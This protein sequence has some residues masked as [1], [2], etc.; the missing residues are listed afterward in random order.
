MSSQLILPAFLVSILL[1]AVLFFGLGFIINMLI[2]T[3]WLPAILYPV[4]I[5]LYIDDISTLDY[6]TQFGSSM[7]ALGEKMASLAPSDITVLSAGWIGAI[8][9]GIVMKMLRSRGYQMF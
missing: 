2:K 9:S 1:F 7:P 5:L 4:I 6:F 8:I 3:A